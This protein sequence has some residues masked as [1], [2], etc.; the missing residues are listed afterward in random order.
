MFAITD[1]ILRVWTEVGLSLILMQRLE[2]ALKNEIS[3]IPFRH[4][5]QFTILCYKYGNS[6]QF[7]ITKIF[8]IVMGK[9][10]YMST[11]KQ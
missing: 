5:T 4:W 3:Y 1:L 7:Y 10:Q 11:G 6:A 2:Q 8:F 9:M